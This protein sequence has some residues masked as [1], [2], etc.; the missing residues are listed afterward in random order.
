MFAASRRENVVIADTLIFPNHQVSM[1]F[2]AT[3]FAIKVARS[4]GSFAF[5]ARLLI[6]GQGGG[7]SHAQKVVRRPADEVHRPVLAARC[8]GNHNRSRNRMIL[9]VKMLKAQLSPLHICLSISTACG[10][11]PLNST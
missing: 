11:P 7:D 3:V 8:T 9:G 10:H 6:R 1:R 5:A 2:L 4:G